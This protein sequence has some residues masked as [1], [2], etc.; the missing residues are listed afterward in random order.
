MG[1]GIIQIRHATPDDAAGIVKV[2]DAAWLSAYQGLIPHLQLQRMINRRGLEWWRR[3]L[4][5][6]D[7]LVLCF[8]GEPQGY[9]S[10]GAGRY[11]R[12]HGGG[13]IYELYLAPA[14]QGIG[15][16]KRLFSAA[17]RE[18]VK[19][20]YKGMT[21]WA[22]EDNAMACEFYARLGGVLRGRSAERYG[23]TVLAKVAFYWR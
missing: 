20:G 19:L 14:F 1:T 11:A 13:E 3:T 16:G 7:V 6:R 17:R 9:A 12:L 10:I 23:E 21:V 4:A 5:E 15:L 8:D 22:L 18:L 2:H